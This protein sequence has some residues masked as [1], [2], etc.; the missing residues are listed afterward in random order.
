MIFWTIRGDDFSATY[1]AED[2]EQALAH[3]NAALAPPMSELLD[4]D[5]RL[6]A[7]KSAAFGWVRTTGARPAAVTVPG[8]AS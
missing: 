7:M 1:E 3:P 5:M 2:R 6:Q 8:D 4:G